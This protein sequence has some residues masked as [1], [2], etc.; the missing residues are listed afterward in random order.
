MLSGRARRHRSVLS[1]TSRPLIVRRPRRTHRRPRPAHRRRIV[2]ALQPALRGRESG[3][4]G[5]LV[6]GEFV[7]AFRANGYT[8]LYANTACSPSIPLCRNEHALRSATA[9]ARS[10]VSNSPQLLVANRRSLSSCRNSS[11]AERDDGE[12]AGIRVEQRIAVGSERATNSPP[13]GPA[14][15]RSR[16]R[17]AG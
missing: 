14:P 7:R 13:R 11:P 6:A 17:S 9:F 4:A 15:T 16:P 5:G 2:G 8:L 3:G 1:A 10:F 12:H